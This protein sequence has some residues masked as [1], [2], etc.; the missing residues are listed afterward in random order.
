[1]TMKHL[2]LNT[3]LATAMVM[4]AAPSGY[5]AGDMVPYGQG[6]SSSKK[7]VTAT[8][9]GEFIKQD[10]NLSFSVEDLLQHYQT[11]EDFVRQIKEI[12]PLNSIEL[13]QGLVTLKNHQKTMSDLMG[14]LIT[15]PAIKALFDKQEQRYALFKSYLETSKKALEEVVNNPFFDESIGQS[16]SMSVSAEESVKHFLAAAQAN[17]PHLIAHNQGIQELIANPNLLEMGTSQLAIEGPGANQ[18]LIH[19]QQEQKDLGQLL[20]MGRNKNMSLADFIQGAKSPQEAARL[21]KTG[22]EMCNRILDV[23]YQAKTGVEKFNVSIPTIE[24]DEN[25]QKLKIVGSFNNYSHDA[26]ALAFDGKKDRVQQF[27]AQWRELQVTRNNLKAEWTDID[28]H[29]AKMADIQQTERSFALAHNAGSDLPPSFIKREDYASDLEYNTALEADRIKRF[30]N[31]KFGKEW[32]QH[33]ELQTATTE[34]QKKQSLRADFKQM[35]EG[36]IVDLEQG[37]LASSSSS[38]LLKDH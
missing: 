38:G 18:Q 25:S 22:L 27:L 35:V 16:E 15:S 5:A 19:N 11:K 14:F 7:L 13:F 26:L 37:K 23:L 31:A 2:F 36:L 8:D 10:S 21:L 28:G 33:P 3:A 17:Y 29:T 1:M 20:R 12:F 30:K 4:V 6:S 24:Q 34:E 9:I 32:D